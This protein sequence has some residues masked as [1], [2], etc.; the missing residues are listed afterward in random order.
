MYN[1][2]TIRANGMNLGIKTMITENEETNSRMPDN[3][4]LEL[5]S[6]A[7]STV[8][9]SVVNRL[10]ILPIGVVSKNRGGASVRRC[11]KERNKERDARRLE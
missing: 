3:A 11:I 10:S 8:L 4:S 7:P 5:F 9:M 1:H 6:K 2:A